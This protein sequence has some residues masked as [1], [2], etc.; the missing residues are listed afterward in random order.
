VLFHTGWDAH[1]RTER[2][3]ADHPF[4][5]ARTAEAWLLRAPALAGIDSHN[6]DDTSRPARP[7]HTRL[8]GAN[9]LICEHLTNLAAL[10]D[11]R[12]PLQRRPAQIPERRHFPGPRVRGGV[13]HRL[14][15]AYVA[16]GLNRG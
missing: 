8:L 6:I 4:L 7:V 14:L 9:V 3:L 10:P 1:W 2:Y 12:L 5:T 15:N 13:R 16:P 11:R